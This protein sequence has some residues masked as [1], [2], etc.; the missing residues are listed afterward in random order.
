MRSRVRLNGPGIDDR[1]VYDPAALQGWKLVVGE[2]GR[3]MW[4]NRGWSGGGGGRVLYEDVLGE[5]ER[6]LLETDPETYDFVLKGAV[7]ARR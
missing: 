5:V 4:E 2:G 7:K 1:G 3:P 6:K